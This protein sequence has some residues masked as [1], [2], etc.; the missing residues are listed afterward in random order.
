[1]ILEKFL[2]I[3]K[4]VLIPKNLVSSFQFYF[5]GEKFAFKIFKN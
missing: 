2:I 3:E 5:F 1:M 4:N